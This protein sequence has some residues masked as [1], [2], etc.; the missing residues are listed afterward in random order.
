MRHELPVG[1]PVNHDVSRVSLGELR[2]SGTPQLVTVA[3]MDAYATNRERELFGEIR[4]AGWVCVSENRAHG[5]D[6]RELVEYLPAP[7]ISRVKNQADTRESFV[8][9]RSHQTM[10]VRDQAYHMRVS[11]HRQFYILGRSWRGYDSPP[12]SRCARFGG[13][14]WE[15]I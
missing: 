14:F 1:V 9:A 10:C 7:H 4:I 13:H 12:N 3:H 2:R 11:R 6:Q 15:S 5:G 8:H